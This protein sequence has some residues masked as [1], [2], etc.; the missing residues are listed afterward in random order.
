MKQTIKK[1]ILNEERV[2]EKGYPLVIMQDIK[3]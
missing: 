3:M 2:G 1:R